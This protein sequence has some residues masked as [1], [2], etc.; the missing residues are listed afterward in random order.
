MSSLPLSVNGALQR[1]H[2]VASSAFASPQPGQLIAMV[3]VLW[4]APR[5]VGLRVYEAGWRGVNRKVVEGLNR[6]P[7]RRVKY[8]QG[9]FAACPSVG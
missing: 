1:R 5:Q 9:R 6:I 2:S 8:T 4:G 7:S 3:N